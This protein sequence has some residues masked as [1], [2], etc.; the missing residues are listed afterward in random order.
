M[1]L[2]SSSNGLHGF[3]L[4]D[5]CYTEI[6]GRYLDRLTR[7]SNFYEATNYEI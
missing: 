3:V 2:V 6:S 4:I 7:S 5:I 1:F